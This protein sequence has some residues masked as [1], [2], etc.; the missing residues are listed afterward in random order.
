MGLITIRIRPTAQ[1]FYDTWASGGTKWQLVSDLND[2]SGVAGSPTNETYALGDVASPG[3]SLVTEVKVFGRYNGQDVDGSYKFLL[4]L[5]GVDSE[6]GV[7]GFGG[8]GLVE[9]SAVFLTKPGGGA[10]TVFDV[11]ALEAGAWVN[12]ATNQP[13]LRELFVDITY[14]PIPLLLTNVRRV[15]TQRALLRRSPRLMVS[16]KSPLIVA[17]Y[18]PS[19]VVLWSHP[20]APA[21]DV[22]GWGERTWERMQTLLLR[23]TFDPN[24][25]TVLA[26]CETWRRNIFLVYDEG[27]AV[28]NPSAYAN[29]VGRFHAGTRTYTRASKAYGQDPSDGIVR[30]LAYDIEQLVG[31]D[32][33]GAQFATFQRLRG[34]QLMEDAST[35][36]LLRSSFI[37]GTTGLTPTG[38]GTNGSAIATDATVLLFDATITPSALKFTAGSPH[39]ADLIEAWPATASWLANTVGRLSID[40]QNANV[41][42]GSAD[43]LYWRLQRSSDSRYFVDS[44]GTWQVGVVDNELVPSFGG[45]NRFNSSLIDV[46]ASAN[47]LTLRILFKSGGTAS[48]VARVFHAQLEKK[49]WATSRIPTDAATVARAVSVL[50][51]TNTNTVAGRNFPRDRGTLRITHVSEGIDSGATSTLLYLFKLDYDANNWFRGYYDGATENLVFS[52]RVAGVTYTAEKVIGGLSRG[53]ASIFAFRWHLEE[54]LGLAAGTVSVF[55]AGAKGTDAVPGAMPVEVASSTLYVG[56]DGSS[57]TANGIIRKWEITPVVLTDEEIA[58]DAPAFAVR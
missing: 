9:V 51:Y 45:L 20:E 44:N 12:Y 2:V 46:G 5:N 56:C 53:N 48:R 37:S 50:S 31:L 47:T 17:D 30:E 29:G 40:Y 54:M 6:S 28:G 22:N 57:S 49:R 25:L 35:N 27:R 52:V 3:G 36:E 16:A 21:A 23:T 8:T 24:D 7:L 33:S 18:S 10:F 34:G 14:N 41:L 15:V 1:G 32:F 4:R 38:T 58:Q 11:N 39:A 26:E 42:F 43:S 13:I 19:D 55:A